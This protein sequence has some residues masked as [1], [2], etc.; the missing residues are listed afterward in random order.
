[1]RAAIKFA[2]P[3][4]LRVCLTSSRTSSRGCGAHTSGLVRVRGVAR[5]G[6]CQRFM[7]FSRSPARHLLF[8][9]LLLC[10]VEP[11]RC[12]STEHPRAFGST[13]SVRRRYPSSTC[14]LRIRRLSS[15]KTPCHR[16]ATREL[17]LCCPQT[18]LYATHTFSRTCVL[19]DITLCICLQYNCGYYQ[20][21]TATGRRI[22]ESTR[23]QHVALLLEQ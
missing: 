4:T 11:H 16:V 8:L 6:F 13:E 9:L 10:C 18:P 23:N 15:G 19:L 22:L 2:S 17:H 21:M 7:G 1:M 5:R 12:I 14:L 3:A 20:W